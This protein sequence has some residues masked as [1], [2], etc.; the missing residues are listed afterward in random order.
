MGCVLVKL[1]TA[2]ELRLTAEYFTDGAF[3]SRENRT[4]RNRWQ[5]KKSDFRTAGIASVSSARSGQLNRVPD[6]FG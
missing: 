6:D 5:V 2:V 3:H 4:G 1:T